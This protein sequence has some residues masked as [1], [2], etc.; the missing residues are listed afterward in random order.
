M[1][2]GEASETVGVEC[3]TS[4]MPKKFVHEFDNIYPPPCDVIVQR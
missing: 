2:Y 3:E 1:A 4:R